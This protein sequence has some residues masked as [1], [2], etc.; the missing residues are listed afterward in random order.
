[1]WIHVFEIVLGSS[2]V[3]EKDRKYVGP[4]MGCKVSNFP[5]K[6]AKFFLGTAEL[7]E[8][9]AEHY[10]FYIYDHLKKCGKVI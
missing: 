10:L 2:G 9:N 5:Y 3:L 6:N 7:I 4:N 1:M 8:T